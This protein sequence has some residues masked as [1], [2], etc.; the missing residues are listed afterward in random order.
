VY[1]FSQ[2]KPYEGPD[3]PASDISAVRKGY[4][5]GNRVLLSFKNT[6]E[7]G[8]W[9]NVGDSKWPN[10]YT[11]LGIVDYLTLSIGAKVYL[12]N[13]S[14]PVDDPNEISSTTGLE[15]LYYLETYACYGMDKNSGGTINYGIYPV[16][17][18]F[19]ETSDYPAMSNKPESWPPLGWPSGTG[20]GQPFGN[21]LKWPGEWDG[22]F[23]RGIMYADLESYYVSNDAHDQEYLGSDDMLKY[24]PRPGVYIGDKRSDVTIQKGFP[25]G[26]V[27]LRIKARGYQW[28]NIQCRDAIFWE[29][30]I[31]NISD[32]NLIEV[33]F[34]YRQDTGIGHSGDMC[35]QDDIGHF[36]KLEDMAYVWDSDG[37]GA[38]GLVPGVYG[39][40]FLESP[41]KP[42]DGIDNDD[43][44]LVDEKRDNEATAII[45]PID[46]IDD[47]DK[48]LTF[49][50]KKVEDLKDH[51]DADEDQDWVDGDD[52][53]GNGIYDDGENPGDDV[54]LDGVGPGELQYNG[55]DAG[56]SECNHK[57]DFL[58]G[59]GCEPNFALTDI[60]E[61]DMIG[62]TSFH[63]V[64]GGKYN[65]G[66]ISPEH[67]KGAWDCFADSEFEECGEQISNLFLHFG[68]GV[69]PL[70]KGRTER[71]SIAGVHA[72]ED[73]AGLMLP[74]HSAPSLFQKK[75]IVQYI[76]ESD[77]RFASPPKMP[78][79]TATAGDGKVV[80]TWDYAAEKYTREPMLA[81][82]N[83]FEGYKLYKATDKYFSDAE[84][85]MDMYGNPIGKKPIFQC[86]LK[87]GI[88]GAADFA[89]IN[90]EAYYLGDDSGIQ[91]Y[92]VDNDVQNGRTYYYGIVAY[93]YGIDGEEIDITPRRIIL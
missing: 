1:L 41:G 39:M 11:G 76:Y 53:N 90:G 13:D 60:S 21:G 65:L 78:T 79:L 81:N 51:W 32:Y 6:T 23:G 3:D 84:V 14:I 9:P 20:F 34:G 85:L 49:Y 59:Y 68:S 43:D 75:K 58:E 36:D 91:H 72:Y 18:Y 64:P 73:L 5:N 66:E 27:G 63:P 29:Y 88:K 25:W 47:L 24:Y 19:N 67:D 61:S 92:F 40:A 30:D 2:G 17:G 22:R 37:H 55:P 31:S 80:L 46:G 54:G 26:G 35:D 87:D 77:Y 45:G 70:Y 56:G 33:L 89:L 48:Y 93:D 12:K 86:D 28:N 15:N 74:E 38:G 10:D 62:L 4:M 83:D 82:K 52:I 57:P 16:P 42:Y 7:L 44:G 8:M 69:F 71:F 50:N